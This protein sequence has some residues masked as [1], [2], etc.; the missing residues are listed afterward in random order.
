MTEQGDAR[1]NSYRDLHVWQ[2]AVELV[3]EIYKLSTLFPSDE[4][5]G[6]TSQIRRA[7]V[8]VPSNIA[9]G[10]G[11]RRRAQYSHHLDIANG[12][13]KEVE[14]QLIIGGRLGFI[15]KD[16]AHSAWSLLQDTGK[17]LTGLIRS[18]D[19]SDRQ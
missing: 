7:A 5:F 3:E 6:L 1:I 17:M 16:H 8:S 14:T 11:R 9:E 13:L 19:Q 10:Y 2:R 4:R 18:L 12:S 15:D